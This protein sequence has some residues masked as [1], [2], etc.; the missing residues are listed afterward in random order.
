VLTQL[1]EWHPD[2]LR[3]IYRHFP[4]TPIHD[5][6]SLAGQAAEAA[7]AQGY[8]WEM[9]D[10]LFDRYDEW[11]NLTPEAFQDWLIRAAGDLEMD[12][13]QFQDDLLGETYAQEMQTAFENTAAAGI[14]GTPFVFLNE[15]WFRL[16]LTINNLEAV[17]RLNLLAERQYEAY[18]L[19]SLE[20][21]VQ[22]LAYLH[23]EGGDVVIQ[24]YPEYAPLGVN[25]FIFLA[26]NGWYDG[27]YFHNI[28]PDIV[29]E[30]GD[31]TGTGF[32]TPGY[33]FEIETDPALSFDQPGMVGLQ[34][35]GPGT[36]NGL[37]FIT[38]APLSDIDLDL[39]IFGRV[40]EGLELL[41]DLSE[42]EP[43]DDLLSPPE[44]VI[45]SITIE[46]K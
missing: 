41:Q 11:V 19:M 32:G 45:Q 16:P 30:G 25:S 46:E 4:L 3:V 35:F 42:R 12:L 2:D 26:R 21:D 7:G 43:I 23:L 28:Q 6:A 38:L 8:F 9:H 29:V 5:K 10:L 17:L 1:T 27:T 22:Y 18:P 13:G 36:N 39:T 24:L 20:P 34:N 33:S 31:P 37:F 44:E 15:E 14:P 40:I